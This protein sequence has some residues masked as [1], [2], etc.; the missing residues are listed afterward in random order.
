MLL[1]YEIKTEIKTGV[2]T[3]DSYLL[4][5]V[6]CPSEQAYSAF[7]LTP[8]SSQLTNYYNIINNNNIVF[9]ITHTLNVRATT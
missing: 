5:G 6:G 8:V 4:G 9:V 3:T 7:Y 2:R 1:T